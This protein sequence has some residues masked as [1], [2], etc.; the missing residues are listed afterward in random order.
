MALAIWTIATLQ[1]DVELALRKRSPFV[2]PAIVDA[3]RHVRNEEFWFNGASYT[4]ETEDSRVFYD[5]P[6]DFLKVRGAV[7]LRD[8]LTSNSRLELIPMTLDELERYRFGHFDTDGFYH[9]ELQGSSIAY[10]LDRVGKR[11]GLAPETSGGDV[12]EMR[13]TRDFGTPT[14][15]ASTTTSAPPSLSATYTML[16]PDGG[17]FNADFST[18]MLEHGY[19]LLK[20]RALYELYSNYEGGNEQM[21]ANSQRALMR[22]LEELQRLRAETTDIQSVSRITGFI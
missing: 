3:F 7:F 5:L 12:V 1:A 21:A 10:A 11:I 18:P 22:Y 13:Y 15:S 14:Y 4:F 2:I 8:S 6:D 19:K 20:E 16:T 17:T 9:S